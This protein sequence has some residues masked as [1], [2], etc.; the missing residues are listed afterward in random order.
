MSVLCLELDKTSFGEENL[1]VVFMNAA[2][3]LKKSLSIHPVP[4]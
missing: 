1:R 4:F 2:R 3:K